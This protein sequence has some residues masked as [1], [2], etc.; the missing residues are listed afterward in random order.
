MSL[1]ARLAVTLSV[2]V[3]IGIGTAAVAAYVSTRAELRSEIDAF[4]V[5]RASEIVGGQR[6]G[7]R[8]GN[9]RP[10]ATVDR[11]AVDA[12]SVVQLLDRDGMPTVSTG[13]S[14][15]VTAVDV[16]LAER[17]RPAVVR[18]I[19]LDGVDYRM[20]TAHAP[21]GGAVMVARE[22]S[23]TADVLAGLRNR[24][25][26]VG[27][28][29]CA[30]AA[31]AGWFIARRITGPLRALTDTAER[32]ARTEDLSIPIPVRGHDEV[33]RLGASFD[34]MLGALA[35]SREQ[36]QRLVQDAAH[37][38]RTPLTSLRAN[39]ELLRRAPDLPAVERDEVLASVNDELVELSEL[40]T[41]LIELATD[42]RD[43]EP[44]VVVDLPTIVEE[45]VGRFR[46]RSDREVIVTRGPAGTDPTRVLGNVAQLERA[47]TNLLSNADKFSPPGAPVEVVVGTTEVRVRDHGPGIP[48][49]ER[50]R[51]FDRFYRSPTTRTL[52]G[53]GLGLAIVRQV[54]IRHGGRV[55][56]ADVPGGGAEVAFSL[57]RL[58]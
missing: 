27:A 58:H 49:F 43:D 2:V 10:D 6:S 52:P 25:A 23:E 55:W 14:L 41:E 35:T 22:L 28:A 16:E 31:A 37:E 4:L 12:D 7:P 44:D 15:P 45:A 54:V 46:R 36:Q 5:R 19:D 32:V 17:D 8:D 38:L 42:S 53:S 40:F 1:R 39:I 3:A 26:L 9:E 47:V 20:I 57:P 51:V 18:T 56:V 21:G 29:L 13:A 11:V 50:D 33:G 48:A 34:E 30:A 24:L